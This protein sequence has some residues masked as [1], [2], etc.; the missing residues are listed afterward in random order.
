[1]SDTRAIIVELLRNIGGRK[2]VEQYLKHYCSVE[3]QRFA[4]IAIGGGI[5]DRPLR[6]VAAALSFL[7]EVGLYPIVVH[8]AGPRL[9]RALREAGIER[10]HV[11]DSPQTSAEALG[12]I[13]RSYQ[14]ENLELVEALDAQGCPARPITSG[15][16]EAVSD[17]PTSLFGR[18]TGVDEAALTSAIRARMLPIVASLGTSAAGQ[19]LDVHPEEAA[20][21]LARRMK[22]HKVIFLTDEGGLRDARGELLD[23]INLSERAPVLSEEP[24]LDDRDQRRLMRITEL[25]AEL[26]AR[27]SVS[28]TSPDHL[29]RELFTHRGAGTLIRRGE[30]V[31]AHESLDE[32]DQARLAELVATCFGRALAPDY[33]E[34]RAFRRIYVSESYRATAIV[35]A[36][37]GLPYLDKFAVT[38]KAQ[39]EGLGG[40]VWARVRADQP[41]LFWRSRRD[42]PINPWYFEQSEGS[43]RQGPWAVF[44]YGLGDFDQARRCVEVALALP[45][46]L[47][48]EPAA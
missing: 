30:R 22:P 19:L 1:M 10:G 29:A 17:P 24:W 46:S 21:A 18:V 47:N 40:S 7:R 15:V 25:L 45:V 8:S 3:T 2:E 20:I 14:Q 34:Q 41:Q 39:G 5:L 36:E 43:Y 44:W 37:A 35:T 13:R 32:I 11:D 27:S 9:E 33:F 16:L 38:Q 28:I 12:I 6:H 31:E 42:N 48:E 23:A 4:V 26:P